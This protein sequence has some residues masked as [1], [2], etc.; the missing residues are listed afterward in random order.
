MQD[1]E[2]ILIC[3]LYFICSSYRKMA[4]FFKLLVHSAFSVSVVTPL[5]CTDLWKMKGEAECVPIPSK[6]KVR[7]ISVLHEILNIC[8][9]KH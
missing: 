6:A 4:E 8:Q 5:S 9:I 1:V 2:V 7:Y 3:V